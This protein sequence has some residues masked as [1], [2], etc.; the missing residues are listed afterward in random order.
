MCIVLKQWLLN[1]SQVA[2]TPNTLMLKMDY[3]LLEYLMI[4]HE[5]ESILLKE[6]VNLI[7]VYNKNILNTNIYAHD[8]I[9]TIQSDTIT[10]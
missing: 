2:E 9:L 4:F 7:L 6:T 3:E 1:L 5:L 8:N 10:F